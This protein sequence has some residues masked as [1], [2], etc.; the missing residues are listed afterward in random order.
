LGP[1]GGAIASSFIGAMLATQI[2]IIQSQKPPAH[3]GG[4]L[5][6]DELNIGNRRVRQGE[7]AV[8]F[9]QRAVQSGALDQAQRINRDQGSSGGSQ[10]VRLVLADAGR[11]V[12]EL[13]ARETRRPGSR[14]AAAFGGTGVVD[15]YGRAR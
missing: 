2:G 7:A 5:G 13:V 3:D 15:P 14:L 12:G 11:V 10:E 4:T 1:I 9:N 6:A 8:V